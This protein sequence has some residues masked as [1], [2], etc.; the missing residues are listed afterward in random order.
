MCGGYWHGA[1]SNQNYFFDERMLQLWYH[2]RHKTPGTSE[3][4]FIEGLEELSQEHGRV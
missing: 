1:L 3:R 4:K 2:I